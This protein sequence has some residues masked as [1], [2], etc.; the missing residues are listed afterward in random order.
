MKLRLPETG[1]WDH[2]GKFHIIRQDDC[3]EM[4]GNSWAFCNQLI[5][6]D[7]PNGDCV[8]NVPAEKLCS[9]CWPFG[10]DA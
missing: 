9:R 1:R 2:R 10:V 7:E 5:P 3:K 4:R 6:N 8:E